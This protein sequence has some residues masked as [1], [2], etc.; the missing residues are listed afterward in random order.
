MKKMLVLCSLLP[1]TKKKTTHE[2]CKNKEEKKKGGIVKMK[3]IFLHTYLDIYRE[4]NVMS[5]CLY[6]C[7]FCKS[8]WK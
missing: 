3:N 6:E 7:L 4:M 8:L 2:K 1:K 5:V